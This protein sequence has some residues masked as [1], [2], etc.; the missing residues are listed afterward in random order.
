MPGVG[1]LRLSH[2]EWSNLASMTETKT[3]KYWGFPCAS[4]RQ[5]IPIVPYVEG[6]RWRSVKGA[7]FTL[8]CD[9]CETEGQYLIADIQ[10]I[11]VEEVS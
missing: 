1:R 6:S 10:V 5:P 4:C 2:L 3:K 8:I 7:T 11:P 9:E